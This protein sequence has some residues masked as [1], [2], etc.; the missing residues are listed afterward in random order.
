MTA[1]GSHEWLTKAIRGDT[2]I[3]IGVNEAVD[4]VNVF[5]VN[6]MMVM[7]I[8]CRELTD[9]YPGYEVN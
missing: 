2:H 1:F 7:V 6:C 8:Q 4:S 5:V 3:P 9:A